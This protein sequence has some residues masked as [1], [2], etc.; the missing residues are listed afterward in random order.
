MDTVTDG[1][2]R[3]RADLRAFPH[4]AVARQA[5]ETYLDAL[6]ADPETV[7]PAF[8][9][10]GLDFTGA[11]L[12][13]LELL[14]AYL[15]QAILDGVKLTG[16]SLGGASLMGTRL[17]RADLSHASLRKAQGR[18]SDAQAALL[19]G[20][21][22]RSSNFENA[23]MRHADLRRAQLGNS[24]LTGIDLRE[25]NLRECS[26]GGHKTWTARPKARMAHARVE[27]AAGH[28]TGPIDIGTDTPYLLDG[29]DLQHWFADHGATQVEIHQHC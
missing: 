10:D 24:W 23:D 17:R 28:I 22:L 16:A 25:A 26:F 20:A 19:L 27:G 1:F 8:A 15:D 6:P 9:G 5:L 7:L 18:S 13:N 14:G 4:D 21:D 29:E 3:S 2:G 12:T 11:D